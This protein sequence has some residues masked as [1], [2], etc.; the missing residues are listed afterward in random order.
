MARIKSVTIETE[1]VFPDATAFAEAR[2]RA[3]YGHKVW[4]VYRRADGSH[5]IRLYSAAA[6]KAAMLASGTKGR[7]W[8]M[9]ASNGISNVCLSWS[10]A[11]HL[12]RCARGAERHGF[13][14]A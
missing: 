8:W 1:I 7:F 2:K 5:V 14:A 12:F 4:L 3:R 13:S 6:I 9:S 10:F 11:V